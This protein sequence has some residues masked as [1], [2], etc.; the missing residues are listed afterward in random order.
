MRALCLLRE[1]PVYRRDAFRRGLKMAGFELVDRLDK[2]NPE[3][4]LVIWNRYGHWDEQARLFEAAKARVVVVENG[5]LGKSWLN[6]SWY[7]MALGHHA[8]AGT[9]VDGGPERW[10]SL[11]VDL[12]PWRDDSGETVIF[13]QRGIGEDGIRSPD[14]W[15]EKIKADIGGRI[16]PHPGNN[17]A[18]IPLEK[19]LKRASRV[20]TWA[21]SAALLA[22][23]LGVPVWYAMPRWI[24]AA[25]SRPLSDY[26]GSWMDKRHDASRLAMFRCLVWAMWRLEE[27]ESGEAFRHLLFR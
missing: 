16:R 27:V 17:E 26:D 7:A 13:G 8:G 22:L 14:H 20:L 5:Y 19:D 12:R 4:V 3:D 18:V 10:D 1:S 9:W 23:I 24:G 25:A 2:P 21:S 15:A 11:G 6:G